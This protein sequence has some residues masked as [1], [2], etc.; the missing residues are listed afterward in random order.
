M[1]MMSPRWAFWRLKTVFLPPDLCT[2][3]EVAEEGKTQL[4]REA[5][6]AGGGVSETITFDPENNITGMR[7]GDSAGPGGFVYH[8]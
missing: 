7:A 6:I 3:C 8:R 5:T 1:L 2:Y 4:V